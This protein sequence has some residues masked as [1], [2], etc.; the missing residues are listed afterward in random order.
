L[1]KHITQRMSAILKIRSEIESRKCF[2]IKTTIFHYNIYF[3][4]PHISN[5]EHFYDDVSSDVKYVPRFL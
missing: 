2:A 4:K 3:Y 1:Y 5:D